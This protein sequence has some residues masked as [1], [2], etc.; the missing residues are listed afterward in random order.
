MF[1]FSV[2]FYEFLSLDDFLESFD[3]LM[4]V[5]VKE[6]GGVERERERK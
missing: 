5:F 3:D 2:F 6:N 1:F 4:D